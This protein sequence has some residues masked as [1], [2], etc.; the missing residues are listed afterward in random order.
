MSQKMKAFYTTSIPVWNELGFLPPICVLAGLRV[1][2]EGAGTFFQ[3][4]PMVK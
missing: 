1:W 4:W 2:G 3:S